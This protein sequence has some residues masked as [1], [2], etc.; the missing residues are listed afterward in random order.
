[1]FTA[2]Q[3]GD[4]YKGATGRSELGS[5]EVG[6]CVAM[7]Q[8]C[9]KQKIENQALQKR[10]GLLEKGFTKLMEVLDDLD[11]KLGTPKH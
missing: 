7:S 10:V 6:F 11:K 8:I 4:I 9:Q 3:I 1:M 5:A 2:Q